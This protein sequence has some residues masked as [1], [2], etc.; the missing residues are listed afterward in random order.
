MR[1]ILDMKMGNCIK[2]NLKWAV[3]VAGAHGLWPVFLGH[4]F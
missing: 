2:W 3:L 4:T 1:N